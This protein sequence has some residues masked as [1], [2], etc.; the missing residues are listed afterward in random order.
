[1]SQLPKKTRKVFSSLIA[2]KLKEMGLKDEI[3]YVASGKKARYIKTDDKGQPLMK[4]GQLETE[5]RD[6][7]VAHNKLRSSLKRLRNQSLEV[8]MSFLRMDLTPKKEG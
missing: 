3:T 6:I 7:P 2:K 5:E 1:M 4:D 8:I